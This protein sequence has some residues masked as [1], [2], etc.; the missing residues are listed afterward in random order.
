[1]G[2]EEKKKTQAEKPGW[3]LVCRAPEHSAAP[4]AC[5]FGPRRYCPSVLHFLLPK[6]LIS[7]FSSLPTSEFYRGNAKH[8]SP[9]SFAELWLPQHLCPG[10]CFLTLSQGFVPRP[11]LLPGSVEDFRHPGK[12]GWCPGTCSCSPWRV[13]PQCPP[14]QDLPG[15]SGDGTG[16]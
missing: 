9:I 11:T 14:H 3:W 4:W 8:G 16:S 6:S 12:A 15:G 7:A 1:M 5:G 13:L 10:L 2:R